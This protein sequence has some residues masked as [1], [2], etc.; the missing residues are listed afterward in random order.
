MIRSGQETLVYFSFTLNCTY[1]YIYRVV[2]YTHIP[3]ADHQLA[4]ETGAPSWLKE[5]VL[6]LHREYPFLFGM[7]NVGVGI[8]VSGALMSVFSR[9]KP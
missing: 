2:L 9:S 3:C 6:Q 4:Q 5:L 1:L 8:G 7:I